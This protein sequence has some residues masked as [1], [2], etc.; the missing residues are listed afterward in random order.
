MKGIMDSK[1]DEFQHSAEY[2]N[3][4]RVVYSVPV[5]GWS[6]KISEYPE[7]VPDSGKYRKREINLANISVPFAA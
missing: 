4:F 3:S 1:V 5:P 2:C 7:N 6:I